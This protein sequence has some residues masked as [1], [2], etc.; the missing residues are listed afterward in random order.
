MWLAK[1]SVFYS[2]PFTEIGNTPSSKE[3]ITQKII[4]EPPGKANQFAVT[5]S[6]SVVN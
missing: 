2:W 4:C 1:P 3:V 5:E 6:R